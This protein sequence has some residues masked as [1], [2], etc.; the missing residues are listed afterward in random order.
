MARYSN[1][2]RPDIVD[3]EESVGRKTQS[4]KRARAM[5]DVGVSM[6]CSDYVVYPPV[7]G[8]GDDVSS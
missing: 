3:V 7:D 1:R 2:V 8:A 4:N 5:Q 6:F